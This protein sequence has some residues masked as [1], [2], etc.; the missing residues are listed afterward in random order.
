MIDSLL[1]SPEH[2]IAN[3]AGKPLNPTIQRNMRRAGKFR[4]E[5]SFT[6]KPFHLIVRK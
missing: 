2:S 3:A 1:F 5:D 4:N 6:A